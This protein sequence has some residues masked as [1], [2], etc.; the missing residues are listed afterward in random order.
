ME[1]TNLKFELTRILFASSSPFSTLFAKAISWSK[2]KRGIL[3]IS[4][5]Y[6]LTGSETVPSV[7]TVN[8]S[9]SFS[10]SSIGFSLSK[11]AATDSKTSISLLSSLLYNSSNSLM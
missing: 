1:T 8:A 5:K 10:K 3:P 7:K 4:F 9:S 6:I 11:S 2:V